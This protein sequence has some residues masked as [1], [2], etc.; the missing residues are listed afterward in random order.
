MWSGGRRCGTWVRAGLDHTMSDVTLASELRK[1]QIE[2]VKRLSYTPG[3]CYL[4][5]QPDDIEIF[6]RL[7]S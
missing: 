2:Y 4:C 6:M 7:A 3:H 1:F 5:K